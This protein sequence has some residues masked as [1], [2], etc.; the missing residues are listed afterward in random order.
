MGVLQNSMRAAMETRGYSE[1]TVAL[2]LSCVRVFAYHFGRSPLE[3]SAGEIESFFHFLR[4]Q[5]KSDSTIHLYYV[6]LRFFYRLN[7]AIDR[8]PR[9]KFRRMRYRVHV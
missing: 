6:S 8:M 4:R 2:Y 1:S 9:L 3:V 5:N 7:N